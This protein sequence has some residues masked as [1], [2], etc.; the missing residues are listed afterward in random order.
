V[1]EENLCKRYAVPNTRKIHQLKTN[2]AG[3]KQGGLEVVDF[4]PTLMG[5]WS[6]LNNYVK[7]PQCTCGKCECGVGSKVVKLI[8][9]SILINFSWAL[10][11][12]LTQAFEVKY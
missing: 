5:M 2:I 10:R 4:Y 9:R 7:I 1:I 12:S 3:C 11:M 8:K 6:E